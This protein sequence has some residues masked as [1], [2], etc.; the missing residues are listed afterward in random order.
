MQRRINDLV[1][2]AKTLIDLYLQ[3]HQKVEILDSLG[4]TDFI[5][6][7]DTPLGGLISDKFGTSR[8]SS[9]IFPSRRGREGAHSLRRA[10][11]ETA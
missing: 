1:A 10:R 7:L 9:A 2:Y 4:T 11:L 3:A 6:R 5:D 8:S